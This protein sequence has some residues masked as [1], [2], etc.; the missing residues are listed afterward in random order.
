MTAVRVEERLSIRVE[1]RSLARHRQIGHGRLRHVPERL[2]RLIGH[3]GAGQLHARSGSA[4]GYLLRVKFKFEPDKGSAATSRL[5]LQVLAMHLQI[6]QR[7]QLL[8]NRLKNI[9][10]DFARPIR[11]GYVEQSAE[12][13]KAD[14][15]HT[16]LSVLLE[17][18]VA[19]LGVAG[20][21]GRELGQLEAGELRGEVVKQ[22]RKA[23][24]HR[25][26]ECAFGRAGD[27]ACEQGELDDVVLFV[28]EL[29]VEREQ[30]TVHIGNL[31]GELIVGHVP[32]KSGQPLQF[33]ERER[34]LVRALV[35]HARRD[36]HQQIKIE[37]GE[38]AQRLIV[39]LVRV[40]HDLIG[41][42]CI[43]P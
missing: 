29:E 10:V 9:L 26:G 17:P 18:P 28:L 2:P 21:Q 5:L 1:R 16:G 22:E 40:L 33:F 15:P 41:H 24:V 20:A 30:A 27:E 12:V 13:L 14:L 11:F 39:E 43:L 8:L 34:H 32:L 36:G 38:L 37:R 7:S 6:Q 23:R 35:P 3:H 4:A 19:L 25:Y 42:D 31:L